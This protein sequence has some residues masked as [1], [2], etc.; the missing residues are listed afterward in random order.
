[1]AYWKVDDLRLFLDMKYSLKT[2][3]AFV[4]FAIMF[5]CLSP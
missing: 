1:M 3:G 2:I 4:V 5:V